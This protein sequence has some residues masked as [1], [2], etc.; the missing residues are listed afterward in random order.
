M[1]YV[2][3][4]REDGVL[5]MLDAEEQPLEERAEGYGD[6]RDGDRCE[7]GPDDQGVPLPHPKLADERER[8]VA[9]F[10]EEGLRR[11]GNGTGVEEQRSHA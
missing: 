2:R 6:G 5:V 3:G 8:V 9:R 7:C 10:E 4:E 11:E 1:W